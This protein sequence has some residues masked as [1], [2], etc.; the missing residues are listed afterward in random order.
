[1]VASKAP[2][3]K[4]GREAQSTA[5]KRLSDKL[6]DLSG[7][8]K[9]VLSPWKVFFLQGG[10][11][12][13]FLS[14]TGIWSKLPFPCIDQSILSKSS[15]EDICSV[16]WH[17]AIFYQRKRRGDKFAQP[18]CSNGKHF[19]ENELQEH[20]TWAVPEAWCWKRQ[21]HPDGLEGWQK[22]D[23]WHW[24][25]V[26]SRGLMYKTKIL[27]RNSQPKQQELGTAACMP[28]KQ[29]FSN[30]LSGGSLDRLGHCPQLPIR[31]TTLYI[32]TGSCFY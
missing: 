13:G 28:L 14:L 9:D 26:H 20:K 6:G 17:M 31:A 32:C 29:W 19:S 12:L 3:K 25:W 23:V 11:G 30:F 24:V 7:R 1:M 15:W 8:D 21:H 10:L 2:L 16:S 27:N 5:H 4:K 18:T 22:K